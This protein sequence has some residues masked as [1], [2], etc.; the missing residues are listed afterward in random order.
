M[1]KKSNSMDI[2]FIKFEKLKNNSDYFEKTKASIIRKYFA[3][4]NISNPREVN[5]KIYIKDNFILKRLA[6]PKKIYRS[7][8][9]GLKDDTMIYQVPISHKEKDILKDSIVQINHDVYYNI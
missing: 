1:Q 6:F 8:T 5:I 7:Y 9:L 4:K 3:D 2:D